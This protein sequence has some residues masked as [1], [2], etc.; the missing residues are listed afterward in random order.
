MTFARLRPPPLAGSVHL[1]LLVLAGA[2]L[3]V[4]VLLADA[5][6]TDE[7]AIWVEGVVGAPPERI[8][9]LLAIPGSSD[10]DVSALLF[11]GLMRVDGS[12]QALPDLAERWE[13]TPDGRTYTFVL[14]DDVF[15]HDGQP[16]TAADVA[17]T[18]GL[19]HDLDFPGP[20]SLAAQWRSVD[21]FVIDRRTVLLRLPD[22]SVDFISRLAVAILP[23]HLLG[24][25]S[26]PL[27][28]TADF[29]RAPV[30][31][32]P[33]RLLSLGADR[34]VLERN[35]SYHRGAPSI[36]RIE[37]HFFSSATEQ[38]DALS[39]GAIGA[40]LRGEQSSPSERELLMERSDLRPVELT[41]HALTLLYFNNQKAP[42][43][44]VSLRRAVAASLDI[45][46]LLTEAESSG[47]RAGGVLVAGSWVAQEAPSAP[48]PE[49]V[50]AWLDAGYRLN[51]DGQLER[52]GVA[53]SLT[54]M[55]NTDPQRVRLAEAIA[56]QLRSWGVR[57]VVTPLPATELLSR[58]LIPR[59]YQLALFGW[60]ANIDPDPYLGWH[61]S[62]I[63]EVGGNIAG[64]QDQT[65][66]AV[67]EAARLTVDGGERRALYAI[68]ETRFIEQAAS[69]VLLYPA[70]RY[71]QPATL[72]GF[73][74]G[75]LF[76]PSDRFRDI[77]L[78]RLQASAES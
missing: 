36:A 46:R 1:F 58:Q 65:A 54:L 37:L 73:E 45:D 76:S 40:A 24:D 70:R 67:L 9:P 57:V 48:R 74:T 75:L 62:Q 16:V 32:G 52:S 14:R 21:L 42:L 11:N 6:Q 47:T 56:D 25:L 44:D 26:W 15:W 7:P 28:A 35:T 2:A 29:N 20:A 50:Q 12:G 34:A 66:D 49:P 10:A 69:V 72:S 55:T 5:E 3:V 77:H 39:R 22:P 59:D 27:L 78:W 31:T 61:T 51:R 13:L 63:S 43:H 8:N 18:I 23:A 17:F 64:F 60:E 4:F 41:R 68:F 19:L 71:V 33:F 53:L 30:G 38:L